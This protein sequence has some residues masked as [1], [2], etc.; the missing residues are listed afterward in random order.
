[1]AVS[2]NNRPGVIR[3]LRNQDGAA[4]T[5]GE[6]VFV[7]VLGLVGGARGGETPRFADSS[8]AGAGRVFL[9]SIL[10]SKQNRLGETPRIPVDKNPFGKPVHTL[11][12]VD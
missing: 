5:R 9:N 7:T 12:A 2:C 6:L 3:R 1:M 10:P 8:A 4:S 11:A